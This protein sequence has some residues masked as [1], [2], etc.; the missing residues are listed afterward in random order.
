V[1]GLFNPPEAEVV[2]EEITLPPD[3]TSLDVMQAIYRDPRQPL[4]RRMRA[5]QAAL[6]FEHPKLAVT[7]NVYS[8]ASQMEEMRIRGKSN[9]IDAKANHS[10]LHVGH[11]Q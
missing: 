11:D 8:F 9:V 3:A 4:A 7:T 6:P 5:A 2:E 1:N 10:A